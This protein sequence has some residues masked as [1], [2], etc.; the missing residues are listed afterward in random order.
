[1]DHRRSVRSATPYY[2]DICCT[3][4]EVWILGE[5]SRKTLNMKHVNWHCSNALALKQF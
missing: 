3:D 1:M 5:S 2:A 4:T